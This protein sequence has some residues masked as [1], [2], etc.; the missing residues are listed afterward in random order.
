MKNRISDL[1]DAL[2]DYYETNDP[3][4]ISNSMSVFVYSAD[5]PN[6]TNGFYFQIGDKPLIC[7]NQNVSYPTQRLVCA[8]ELGHV[9]LH[10]GLN[11]FKLEKNTLCITGKYENEADTFAACLLLHD[12]KEF[13]EVTTVATISAVYGIPENIVRLK[14]GI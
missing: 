3:F 12:L 14:F 11:A 8:H 2:I 13:D 5:L 7:L 9:V 6:E 10:S 1:V 4:E